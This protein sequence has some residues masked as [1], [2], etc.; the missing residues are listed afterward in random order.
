MQSTQILQTK[1]TKPNLP[2]KT[3]LTNPN[4][5]KLLV[6][7]VNTWVC[8]A[9]GNVSLLWNLSL[10]SPCRI[11]QVTNV[12]VI[13]GDPYML[14]SFVFRHQPPQWCMHSNLNYHH[15]HYHH[16]TKLSRYRNASTRFNFTADCL[17]DNLC[18]G[19]E[20][21]RRSWRWAIVHTWSKI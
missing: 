7:A 4:K 13:V 5:P 12:S 1:P 11:F 14:Q 21:R 19:N 8:T 9:F 6:K 2:S 3:H 17:Q 16:L 18:I 20:E 15:C 10:W